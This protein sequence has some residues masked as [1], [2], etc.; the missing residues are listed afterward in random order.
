M[1][2]DSVECNTNNRTAST[3]ASKNNPIG[4]TTSLQEILRRSDSNCREGESASPISFALS[5][6]GRVK[7]SPHA[8]SHQNSVRHEQRSNMLVDD[9]TDRSAKAHEKDAKHCRPSSSER[10][11]R[12]SVQC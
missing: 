2:D 11:H 7:D 6:I 5:V 8:E 4:K 3:T 1:L 12:A 10:S 9:A